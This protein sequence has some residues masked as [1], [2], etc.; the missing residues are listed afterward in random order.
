MRGLILT[1]TALVS[2]NASATLKVLSVTGVSSAKVEADQVR[3][4]FESAVFL[5]H[6][7]HRGQFRRHNHRRAHQQVEWFSSHRGSQHEHV[8]VNIASGFS[9]DW[10][11]RVFLLA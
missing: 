10:H 11:V 1:L 8:V 4:R 2:L 9:I 6:S 3:C 5:Q 7:A